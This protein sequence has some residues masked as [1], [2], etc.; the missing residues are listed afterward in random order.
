MA[1]PILLAGEIRARGAVVPIFEG[2]VRA[3]WS[4]E[5]VIDDP[6]VHRTLILDRGAIVG[7]RTSAAEERIGAIARKIG[8][9]TAEQITKILD[10][11]GERRFG[12]VAV[13]M[14]MVTRDRV[15][16]AVV[17]QAEEI[18]AGA[19]GVSSGTFSFTEG[20]DPEDIGAW[21][22]DGLEVLARVRGEAPPSARADL[23]PRFNEAIAS[24]FQAVTSQGKSQILRTAMASYAQGNI[25]DRALFANPRMY[26]TIENDDVEAAMAA[27]PADRREEVLRTRLHDALQYALFVGCSEI[28]RDAERSLLTRVEPTLA[29][30]SIGKKSAS[31]TPIAR[32][33]LVRRSTPEPPRAQSQPARLEIVPA[34]EGRP[35]RIPTEPL[36]LVR[37]PERAPEPVAAPEERVEEEEVEEEVAPPRASRWPFLLVAAVL[38]GS[39][40]F[41][42]IRI[43]QPEAPPPVP[44]A[45]PSP[46]PVPVPMPAATTVPLPLPTSSES[47]APIPSSPPP[48]GTT[49]TGTV[50][51]TDP[52]HPVWIDGRLV[53]DSP[54]AFV[55][56]CG[57]HVVRIGNAGQ[58]QMTEVP[59]GGEIAL[60]FQ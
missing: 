11:H 10:R 21:A 29:A 58:P 46:A 54:H 32:V 3:S 8:I 56:P 22:L 41:L 34:P 20:F 31:S 55:V 4:G 13:E 16:E 7:A 39:S 17:Q 2:I 59:C 1:R 23:L 47:I 14:G 18:V 40:I 38:L 9:L 35:G 25:V 52:G 27:T 50:R 42:G 57:A 24:I 45:A 33:L 43:L 12:E 44:S 48:S 15:L 37:A 49:T 51:A 6:L 19:S 5:L 53:G 30:L 36:P 28:T 60:G 26:G